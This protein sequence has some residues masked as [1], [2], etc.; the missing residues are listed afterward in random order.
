MTRPLFVLASLGFLLLLAPGCGDPVST[1]SGSVAYNGQKVGDG[2]I[3]FIPAD[4]LGPT[5]GG[6]IANGEFHVEKMI[7]GKKTVQIVAVKKV[8]FARTGV[9]LSAAAREQAM[10]GDTSGIV[11]RADEIPAD[12]EGNNALVIL[13]P[14]DKKL[15]FQ[16]K[17]KH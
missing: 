17:S 7:P 13:E 16:L 12:A 14:G 1:V 10:R 3:T 11:E 4:G 9:D 15:E 5:E 6:P 2:W 8:N